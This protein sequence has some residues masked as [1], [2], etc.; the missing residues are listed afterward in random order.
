MNPAWLGQVSSRVDGWGLGRLCAVVSGRWVLAVPRLAA[1]GVL[2][3][4][5]WRRAPGIGVLG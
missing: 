2:V 1:R 3:R 5:V 4:V